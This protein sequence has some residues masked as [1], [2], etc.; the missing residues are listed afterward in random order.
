MVTLILLLTIAILTGFII[1][2][3]KEFFVIIP[4][5]DDS[6]TAEEVVIPQ[7][8]VTQKVI[9]SVVGTTAYEPLTSPS[10]KYKKV[11]PPEEIESV[12]MNNEFEEEHNTEPEMATELPEDE[13]SEVIDSNTPNDMSVVA[14]NE[15][16]QK[17]VCFDY[18]QIDTA[19]TNAVRN[20][21]LSEEDSMV[22]AG[23]EGT[24]IALQLLERYPSFARIA[25]EALSK[26]DN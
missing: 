20:K 19:I 12:F 14:E 9:N 3:L 22:L 6:S 17:Q 15:S 11:V 8:E 7:T 23:L 18:N 10:S 16:I 5:A 2:L 24:S 26:I 4:K 1:W 25:I 21:P 13:K